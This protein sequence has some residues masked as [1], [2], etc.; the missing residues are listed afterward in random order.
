VSAID[1]DEKN[2]KKMSPG[3]SFLSKWLWFVPFGMRD[4]KPHTANCSRKPG[5]NQDNSV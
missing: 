1:P 5:F 2:E 3:F 4:V